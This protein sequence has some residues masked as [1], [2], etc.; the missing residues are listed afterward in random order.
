[1]RSPFI[2]GPLIRGFI[3]QQFKYRG[4]VSTGGRKCDRE[5]RKRIA[6]LKKQKLVDYRVLTIGAT[7][8]SSIPLRISLC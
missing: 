5:I 8:S 1:M 3:V 7:Q 2:P 4:S 6:H